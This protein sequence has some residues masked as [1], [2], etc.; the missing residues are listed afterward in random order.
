MKIDVLVDFILWHTTL[1]AFNIFLLLCLILHEYGLAHL[2]MGETWR[3]FKKTA[4]LAGVVEAVVKITIP[5]LRVRAVPLMTPFL[6]NVGNRGISSPC[7]K[8]RVFLCI[9]VRCP[10]TVCMAV[11]KR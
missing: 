9:F 6:S 11:V 1:V 2:T 5:T 4:S 3:Q 10:L 8:T 7:R